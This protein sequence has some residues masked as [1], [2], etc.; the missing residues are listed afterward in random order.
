MI[1]E[2]AS[3]LERSERRHH[4]SMSHYVQSVDALHLYPL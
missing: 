1:A 4:C 2:P 3:G